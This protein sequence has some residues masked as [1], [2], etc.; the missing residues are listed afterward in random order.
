MNNNDILRRLRYTFDLKE[1][2]I[3]DIFAA[4]DGIAA[5]E[6]V[7]S[8]LKKEDDTGYIEMLD[9]EMATFLNGFINTK[10]GKREGPQPEPEKRLTNNIVFMKLRIALNLQAEDI[11]DIMSLAEF[12]LSKHELSSFFRKPDN[13]HYCEC[14]DQIL[15]NFLMGLQKRFRA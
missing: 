5:Q 9:V 6:Q 14:K 11:L 8:W 12:N 15:R 10:R 2:E 7:T 13:R 1:L 4:A 3:V